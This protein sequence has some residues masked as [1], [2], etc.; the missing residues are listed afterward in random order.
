MAGVFSGDR[1]PL[2]A[3]G[4]LGLL[5]AAIGAMFVT[6]Q[7]YDRLSGSSPR[8]AP[9]PTQSAPRAASDASRDDE[10]RNRL[11]PEQ[12][13]VTREKGTE[14]AF[15]GKYWNN[16]KKGLYKCVCCGTVLFDSKTKFDSG[17]GWPSFYEPV[18]DTKLDTLIDGSLNTQRTEVICRKCKAHL[19]HVFDDAPK[20]PTGLRYCINSAALDFEETTPASGSGK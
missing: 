16:S 12:Y 10:Y 13:R 14:R 11:E 18:D 6:L 9:M 4:T 19:G 15:S 2:F 20:Q 8:T 1:I 17:S 7:A 5:G 3:M